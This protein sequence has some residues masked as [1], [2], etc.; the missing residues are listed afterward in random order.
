MRL[1]DSAIGKGMHGYP[2][3][4]GRKPQ[5]GK[6]FGGDG[7]E[8]TPGTIPNPEVKLRRGDDRGGRP[9]KIA[10]CRALFF[11]GPPRGAFSFSLMTAIV[12]AYEMDFQRIG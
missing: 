5:D 7:A 8:G 2:V 3:F 1:G 4:K 6:E 12:M 9:L 11:C 10:R